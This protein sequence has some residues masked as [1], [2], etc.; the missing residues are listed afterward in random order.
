MERLFGRGKKDAKKSSS[1]ITNPQASPSST[2]VASDDE[3][4]TFVSTPPQQPLYPSVPA[5]PVLKPTPA[6]S[7]SNGEVSQSST[8][9]QLSSVGAYLDGIPFTLTTKSAGG[10]DIDETTA[11]IE[12]ISERI[13]NVDWSSTEYDF[14]LERSV[15]NE[16]LNRSLMRLQ[17]R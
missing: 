11:R 6:S 12:R 5:Y 14:R 10:T 15:L 3:S 17:S 16:D 1:S 7:T 2:L 9:R 8:Q 13:R 4:F